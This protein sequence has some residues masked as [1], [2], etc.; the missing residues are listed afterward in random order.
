MRCTVSPE[1]KSLLQRHTKPRSICAAPLKT[2]IS[3]RGHQIHAFKL[4]SC[5]FLEPISLSSPHN[6]LQDRY[7]PPSIESSHILAVICCAFRHQNLPYL[8]AGIISF[9]LKVGCMV[10]NHRCFTLLSCSQP[11]L[12]SIEMVLLLGSGP[13][14]GCL[15]P[16]GKQGL[17]W[18]EVPSQCHSSSAL[19]AL[20]PAPRDALLCVM[21]GV[22]TRQG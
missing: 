2:S 19:G 6:F 21:L 16:N 14:R 3:K 18:D 10:G 9:L 12:S 1:R 11:Q 7:G 15:L 8:C 17:D 13:G 5:C 20:A 4:H 22:G